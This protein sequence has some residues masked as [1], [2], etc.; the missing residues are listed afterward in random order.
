M[1]AESDWGYG[2][3][4]AH[5]ALI[6]DGDEDHSAYLW[7]YQPEPDGPGS[8]EPVVN[9]ASL[10][11]HF[12]LQPDARGLE[13]S[14][15][16]LFNEEYELAAVSAADPEAGMVNFGRI[17]NSATEVRMY[18]TAPGP[19]RLLQTHLPG[20]PDIYEVIHVDTRDKDSM[21]VV[22]SQGSP[23]INQRPISQF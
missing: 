2:N 3:G 9:G 18:G 4:R 15:I 20:S 10:A 6:Q 19:H 22:T 23:E 21:R 1:V 14:E 7:H 11:A 12:E 13:V 17:P 8:V 16:F 5:V